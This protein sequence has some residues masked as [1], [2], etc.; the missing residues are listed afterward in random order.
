VRITLGN[1]YSW[2]TTATLSNAGDGN[3]DRLPYEFHPLASPLTTTNYVLSILNSGCPNALKDTF[4]IDVHQK[5]VVDAGHDTAVVFNQPLQLHAS[6][7]DSTAGLWGWAP[8][9][10]LDNPY[11]PDPI[12]IL[13]ANIDSVRYTATASTEVGCSGSASILVKV[14]KTLPDIFV[15]NAFTPGSI[16]NSIFRPVPVGIATFQY[17]RVYNRYGQLVYYT[18]TAGRGWDGRVNGKLQEPGTF[19]WV[20][21]GISYLGKTVNRK[22]TMVLVR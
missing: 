15:P 12:A 9:L 19:V 13:G 22:G 16:A 21:Q 5:I 20:V 2:N 17:F 10:G 8:V 1:T 3:I 4:H 6:S 7:N 14:F 11:T 18:T